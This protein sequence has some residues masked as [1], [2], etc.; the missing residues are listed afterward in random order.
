MHDLTVI[1][2]YFGSN[3]EVI[4]EK[5]LR[6]A[7]TPRQ[8]ELFSISEDETLRVKQTEYVYEFPLGLPAGLDVKIYLAELFPEEKHRKIF[9]V[10]DLFGRGIVH[11][12]HVWVES[13]KVSRYT[14]YKSG[15]DGT[16]PIS[17]SRSVIDEFKKNFCSD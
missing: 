11:Y 9:G 15:Y 3:C 16:S 4:C 6:T 5:Y 12:D 17:L 10:R 2:T 1:T 7:L 13:P 14:I 8:G